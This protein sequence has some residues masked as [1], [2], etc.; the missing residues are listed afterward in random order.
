MSA[1]ADGP[2]D[3]IAAALIAAYEDG[4]Q[5]EWERLLAAVEHAATNPSSMPS[6]PGWD[7]AMAA[8]MTMLRAGQ[9]R[10][11]GRMTTDYQIETDGRVVWVNNEMLLG[12]FSRNGIDV[13]IDGKC[14]GESCSAGMCGLEEWVRFQELMIEHHGIEIGDKYMPQYLKGAGP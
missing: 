12:R 3:A 2:T 10:S 11:R 14:V 6:D 5:A 7:A 8:I 1:R 13:H 9:T 4:R